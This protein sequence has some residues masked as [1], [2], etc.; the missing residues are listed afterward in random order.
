MRTPVWRLALFPVV[1]VACSGGPDAGP[2]TVRDSA[3]IVIVESRGPLWQAGEAWRLSDEPVLTIGV[4]EG[5]EEYQL[6][7]AVWALRLADGSIAVAN[8]GTFEIRVYDAEGRF[9]RH[10]GR[11]GGGPQE[12]KRLGLMWRTPPDS[13]YVND[14][15]N[16]RLAVLGPDGG[17]ARTFR[18]TGLNRNYPMPLGAF[19]DGTFLVSSNEFSAID[20]ARQGLGRDTLLL[21]RYDRNGSLL[22]TVARRPGREVYW[23]TV[24]GTPNMTS[25]P[26]LGRWGFTAVGTDRWYYGAQDAYEIEVFGTDGA[27]Q[28]LIR[29][30]GPN[31][32]VTA[33]VARAVRERLLERDDR[34][35]WHADIPLPATV[36]AHGIM[37]AADDGHLWVQEYRLRGEPQRWAVFDPEGRFLGHVQTPDAD[38]ITQI[39]SDFVLGLWS[40]EMDVEHVR[41][42]RLLK[43]N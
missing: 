2:V 21:F 27:L 1:F 34:L 13:L 9:V 11:E 36:P 30:P 3:G 41:M 15:G 38:R 16:T 29:R 23:T 7:N 4:M 37:L 33:E 6:F 20:A 25:P 39:G 22:D 8:G 42:Y 28:R 24:N 14:F 17:V 19:A 40:D 32:P 35:H 43:P 26:P 18:L 31:R 12:F 10:V 5:P